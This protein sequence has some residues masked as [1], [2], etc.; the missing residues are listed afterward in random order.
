MYL[1]QYEKYIKGVFCYKKDQASLDLILWTNWENA[2]E[3][4]LKNSAL[5][6]RSPM[7]AFPLLMK[8]WSEMLLERSG[9]ALS[10]LWKT[11]HALAV[12]RA[13]EGFGAI[14]QTR[15][16]MSL[17]DGYKI[18]YDSAAGASAGMQAT[19]DLQS[20]CEQYMESVALI[21]SYSGHFSRSKTVKDVLGTSNRNFQRFY[22][23][24]KMS[25][26]QFTLLQHRMMQADS[27]IAIEI[28]NSSKE[29]A[30]AALRDSSSMKTLGYLSLA[31]LPSTFILAVFSTTVFNWQN[32]HSHDGARVVSEGWWI[33]FITC[34]LA[35]GLTVGTWILWRQ[36]M[37]KKHL[38]ISEYQRNQKLASLEKVSI[39]SNV[40]L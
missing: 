19:S 38:V 2:T 22:H 10:A 39:N 30:S 13:A 17:Q 14:R 34:V 8:N 33:Y 23:I 15:E 9:R 18:V 3:T 32:W 29:I 20:I 37:T 21:K 26:T 5:L 40:G 36:G 12:S 24:E 1:R 28:A 11:E 27:R 7:D 25:Q 6:I 31:F 35:T 16:R 4:V